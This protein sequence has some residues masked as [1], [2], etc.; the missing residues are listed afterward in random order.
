MI[1][2]FITILIGLVAYFLSKYIRKY[3]LTIL[4][5]IT[6][7]SIVTFFIEIEIFTEGYLG[8]A[9]FTVVMFAGAFPKQSILSKRLRSVRKEYSI[10]GF[11]TLLPHAVLYGLMFIDGSYPT[12]WFGVISFFIMI[13]L[14]FISFHFIKR[15]NENQNLDEH[16][17]VR[18]FRLSSDIYSFTSYW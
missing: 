18:L 8:L 9:F 7:V 16:S 14:F 13:P 6:M 12:E 10:F 1:G 4:L 17:K 15:K 3:Y 5:M 11:I 2:L